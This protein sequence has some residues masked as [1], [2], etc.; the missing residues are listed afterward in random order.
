M[1]LVYLFLRCLHQLPQG[2]IWLTY[3]D[4][5]IS[6]LTI[7]SCTLSLIFVI[8]FNHSWSHHIV[9]SYE[10]KPYFTSISNEK[11]IGINDA[12]KI[13]SSNSL[14]YKFINSTLELQRT[15]GGSS[16]LELDSSFCE[17]LPLN[18]LI[19][20]DVFTPKNG[21]FDLRIQRQENQ[22]FKD[23]I[24]HPLTIGNSTAVLS[25]N[26]KNCTGAKISL[27]KNTH[28]LT[29]KNL[30]IRELKIH[31]HGKPIW[32]LYDFMILIIC[33]FAKKC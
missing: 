10:V 3:K 31:E 25:V 13:I 15:A 20:A 23:I 18:A 33:L 24:W 27:S 7:T 21:G 11:R 26:S 6:T 16:T 4:K 17:L 1:P 9:P 2:L 19:I 8:L 14:E 32:C 28:Q 12:F 30:Q 5:V 29:L 22:R